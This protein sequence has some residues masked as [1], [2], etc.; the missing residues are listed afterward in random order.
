MRMK[1]ELWCQRQAQEHLLNAVSSLSKF[2]RVPTQYGPLA[3]GLL[4]GTARHLRRSVPLHTGQQNHAAAVSGSR[5]R[6]NSSWRPP[7]YPTSPFH[8]LHPFTPTLSWA[9]ILHCPLCG[10]LQSFPLMIFDCTY[11]ESLGHYWHCSMPCW[12]GNQ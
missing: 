2:M 12:S 1:P 3:I 7:K 9:C 5:H 10:F 11:E 6:P 8:Q 4:Y